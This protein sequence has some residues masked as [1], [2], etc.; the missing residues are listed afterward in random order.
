[1]IAIAIGILLAIV[2]I[3][4]TGRVLAAVVGVLQVVFDGIM[5]WCDRRSGDQAG[6]DAHIART[7]AIARQLEAEGKWD[8][9][10]YRPPNE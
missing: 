9:E 8:W 7:I 3:E 5:D 4:V 6:S 10:V 1:M 2:A